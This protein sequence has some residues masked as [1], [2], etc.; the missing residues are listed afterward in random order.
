MAFDTVPKNNHL[1]YDASDI[2]KH[3]SSLTLHSQPFYYEQTLAV[4]SFQFALSLPT[5]VQTAV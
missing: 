1:D 2:M 5:C 3:P 4:S